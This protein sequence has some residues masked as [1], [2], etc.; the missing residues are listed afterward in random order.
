MFSQCTL[1][2]CPG[3]LIFLTFGESHR[4][5]QLSCSVLFYITRRARGGRAAMETHDIMKNLGRMMKEKGVSTDRLSSDVGIGSEMLTHII[6]GRIIPGSSLLNRIIQVLAVEHEAPA[7]GHGELKSIR[8]RSRTLDKGERK[9]RMESIWRARAWLDEYTA[10]E[11]ELGECRKYLCREVQCPSPDEAAS[12]ARKVLGIAQDAPV[13]LIADILEEGGIKVGITDFGISKTSGFSIGEGDG[14][15]AIIVNSNRGI[16]TERQIFTIAHELGHLLL[17]RNSYRQDLESEHAGEEKEANEFAGS[18][19]LPKKAFLEAWEEARGLDLV[20]KVLL[21]KAYFGVS[22]QSILERLHQ[23]DG[24]LDRSRLRRGFAVN[25]R[26]LYNH[27][28]KNCYEPFPLSPYALYPLR[29]HSLV[30]RSYEQGL[31][32]V[33]RAAGMLS[34]NLEQMRIRI[35]DW[36]AETSGSAT[37]RPAG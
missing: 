37:E 23:L 19:L 5:E 36:R 10:L 8:F 1:F 4:S 35:N 12:H 27:D 3:K 16:S 21:L 28:L 15:P 32:S 6:S 7:A 17:H 20:S 9:V 22:Y 24:N 34:L 26:L 31:I 13:S 2:R 29:F 33:Q 14:G 18:F 11:N 30:R 25:F